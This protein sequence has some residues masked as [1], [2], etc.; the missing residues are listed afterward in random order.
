LDHHIYISPIY[1]TLV[2]SYCFSFIFSF[3]FLSKHLRGISIFSFSDLSTNYARIIIKFTLPLLFAN[4]IVIFTNWFLQ[5]DL[6]KTDNL[7]DL[8]ILGVINQLLN[9]YLFVPVIYGKVI[10]P[11]LSENYQ[12]KNFILIR[13]VLYI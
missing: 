4:I 10:M 5:F 6:N 8:A 1:I 13:R 7:K 11:I 3:Y 2:L 12:N 9:I